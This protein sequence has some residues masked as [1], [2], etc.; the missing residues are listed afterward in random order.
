MYCLW[1]GEYGEHDLSF[2]PGL[3]NILKLQDEQYRKREGSVVGDFTIIKIE[4]DWGKRQQRW[5]RKC[6]RCGE[7]T[8]KENAKD[9]AKRA[10][11]MSLYCHCHADSKESE[12]KIPKISQNEKD[13]KREV[14]IRQH[15]G[16][17]Y[18]SWEVIDYRGY[19]ICKIRCTECGKTRASVYLKDVISQQL[20]PCTHKIQNDYSSDEWIGKR[21]GHLTAIG[22][23]GGLFIVKC[24]CG[25]ETT[26]RGVDLFTR[27]AKKSCGLV[28]CPYSTNEHI[29]S[30]KR[31]ESGF[32]YEAEVERM[33]QDL[34]Y[35]ASRT[36]SIGDYG[37]DIIVTEEDGYQT[38]IQCKKQN[39][40]VGVEAV[41][42][43]YA[44]GRFY[45]C[46][47]F[48]IIAPN[49]FSNNAIIMAKKLGVYLCSSQYDPPEN[50]NEYT[51]SLL[52][53][54]YNYEKP[55]EKPQKEKVSK[56]PQYTVGDFTGS[57]TSVC[58]H[59]GTRAATVRYRMKFMGM[60]L[61]EA[62]FTPTR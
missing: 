10:H 22:R 4:Y 39:D 34:G 18:G 59:Y 57:L 60:A 12:K 7:I 61:E 19:K 25:Q 30:V 33:L 46:T 51:Q 31:R 36:K 26:A 23:D 44:G 16:K 8:Y 5:T 43:V 53:T 50:I 11:G 48:S 54:Y 9:W 40:P 3:E 13:E 41:Q 56:I 55:K 14:L 6:N 38:A 1:N 20:T 37:V 58:N 24:D 47:K 29:A 62:I 21:N 27:K 17:I 52:P 49:G 45:D 15:L 28:G 2:L 32:N 42:E 35:S